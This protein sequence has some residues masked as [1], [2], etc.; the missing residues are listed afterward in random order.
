MT[1]TVCD[2]CQK[3]TREQV[4]VSIQ[5]EGVLTGASRDLQPSY[6]GR[7]DTQ[8]LDVCVPCLNAF[9]GLVR[10]ELVRTGPNQQSMVNR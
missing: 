8:Y 1:Q 5:G 7:T 4:R 3:V 9:L 2:F 6:D 10:G